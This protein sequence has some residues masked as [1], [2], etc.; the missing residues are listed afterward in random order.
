MIIHIV[1]T[2]S[3]NKLIRHRKPHTN[4]KDPNSN[5]THDNKGWGGG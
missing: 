5:N 2:H 4:T 1:L 3:Y